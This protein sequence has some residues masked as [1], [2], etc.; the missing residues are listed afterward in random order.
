MGADTT[1]VMCQ[2]YDPGHCAGRA[3]FCSTS[4]RAQRVE[5]APGP[6]DPISTHWHFTKADM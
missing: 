4:I 6:C 1:S 5:R 3:V 2:E